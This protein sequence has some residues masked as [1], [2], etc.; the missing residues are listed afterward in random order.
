MIIILDRRDVE[1]RGVGEVKERRE[2]ER[3][4]GDELK[5]RGEVE[6]VRVIGGVE[7]LIEK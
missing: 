5:R 1:K 7:K 4:G 6:R 3:D 2:E